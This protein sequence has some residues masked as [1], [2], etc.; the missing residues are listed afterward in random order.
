VIDTPSARERLGVPPGRYRTPHDPTK[1][2]QQGVRLVQLQRIR[3]SNI[4][5]MM[6]MMP[7]YFRPEEAG[8]LDFTCQLDFSGE[9][10]GRWVLRI[11]DERCNVRPGTTDAP[12]LIVRC[13]GRLFLGIHRGE[14]S[15]VGS[16][17]TGRLKLEGRKE[18]FLAFPRLFPVTPGESIV[19][20]IAWYLKRAWRGWRRGGPG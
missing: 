19:H 2:G 20:R 7:Y 11:A 16:L 6:R 3:V 4:D 15:P 1:P 12:D 14:V 18:L 8:L 17:L 10:G 9:G 13:D 5:T